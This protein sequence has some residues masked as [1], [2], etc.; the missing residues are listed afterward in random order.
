MGTDLWRRSV[1]W[2][3]ESPK[4]YTPA[5]PL[6]ITTLAHSAC[7]AVFGGRNPD[8]WTAVMRACFAD[9][10]NV[11]LVFETS[12]YAGAGWTIV[13]AGLECSFNYLQNAAFSSLLLTIRTNRRARSL[14]HSPQMVSSQRN[15][16]YNNNPTGHG[17][18]RFSFLL[19]HRDA[20]MIARDSSNSISLHGALLQGKGVLWPMACMAAVER[21]GY[22]LLSNPVRWPKFEPSNV[23]TSQTSNTR[24]DYLP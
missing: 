8:K 5:A 18:A 15:G 2:L 21:T 4:E 3:R 12:H 1:L 24:I 7:Q 19:P 10:I 23:Q 22:L 17:A 6:L 16:R 13:A 11:V 20:A 14:H 9:T